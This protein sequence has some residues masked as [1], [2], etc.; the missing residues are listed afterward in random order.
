MH[1]IILNLLIIVDVA[2]QEASQELDLLMTAEGFSDLLDMELSESDRQESE[3]FAVDHSGTTSSFKC[4]ECNSFFSSR[5]SL[6]YHKRTLHVMRFEL[7]SL[8]G[9]VLTT[10]NRDPVTG[11]F[12]CRCGGKFL[13]ASSVYKHKSCYADISSGSL[14]FKSHCIY[15]Y[16]R[17]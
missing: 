15:I 6:K 13:S 7:K 2:I 14:V 3:P 17:L 8:D 9:E 1:F 10:F 4:R 5:D 12:T 16:F 11:F